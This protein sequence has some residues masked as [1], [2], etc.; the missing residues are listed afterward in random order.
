MLGES[1][2]GIIPTTLPSLSSFYNISALTGLPAA[3]WL[4]H[5]LLGFTLQVCMLVAAQP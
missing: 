4:T 1:H 5:Q 3:F 2:P